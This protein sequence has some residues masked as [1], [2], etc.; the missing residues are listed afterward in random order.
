[1]M[2]LSK[3]VCQRYGV[4]LSIL[5][6]SSILTGFN[7]KTNIIQPTK[8]IVKLPAPLYKGNIS[9][10]EALKRRRSVRVYK[11]TPVTLQQVSQL[12]WAAQGVTSPSGRG[13]RT[14]PSAGALYP[15]E[16]YLVSGNITGLPAGVYQYVP[17]HHAL[18]LLIKGDL[19]NNLVHAT[20]N[21][22]SVQQGAA[23]IVITADYKRT[24]IKYGSRGKRYVD[25]EAGH[26]AENIGLQVVSLSLGTVTIGSFD[27]SSVK[28]VLNLP[29]NEDP[30]YIMP[31]GNLSD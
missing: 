26:A 20:Q 17:E 1:M 16:I 28:A 22:K 6:A 19:R 27:D 18:Q 11:Q 4:V 14:A 12:L 7:F 2:H 23:D 30:L 5:L 31:V 9:I 21:Q 29:S 10:E 13:L 24:T 25:M 15:L 8:L 3:L